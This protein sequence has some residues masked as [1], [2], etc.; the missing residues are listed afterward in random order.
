MDS[1]LN[2]SGSSLEQFE[3]NFL[4][5]QDE[6]NDLKVVL[7]NPTPHHPH[8]SPLPPPSLQAQSQSQSQNQ[9][10]EDP[11]DH[12][13]TSPIHSTSL[14][15]LFNNLQLQNSPN[16]AFTSQSQTQSQSPQPNKFDLSQ[17]NIFNTLDDPNNWAQQS[18]VFE[19]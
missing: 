10:P 5:I 2:I 3:K 12:T 7:S 17:T 9:I 15:N 19:D 16:K 8:R 1:P 11:N 13:Y 14:S 6:L 4:L 18:S